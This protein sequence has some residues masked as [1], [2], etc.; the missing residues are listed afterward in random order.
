MTP[1]YWRRV[2]DIFTSAV[3]LPTGE[4]EA[5][6]TAACD[7]DAALLSEVRSLLDADATEE[8]IVDRPAAAFV[9]SEFAGN[10][11]DP[12]IG[13]RIG[14]YEIVS[15][16]GYGGMG[17]VYRALRVDA[18]YEKEV[19]IKLVPGGY[20]ASYVLQRMRAE[21]QIL[22][23][24]EHPNIARLIDGGATAEGSP[25]LVMELVD[26]EPL[27]RHAAGRRLS[28]RER[29]QL[30]LDVCAAVSYAHQRLVVHR[31]LKPGNILV[32]ANGTVKLLDFGIAKLLQPPSHVAAASAT[33][34]VMHALTPGYSSPEQLL[35]APITTASDV[36]SLGVVLY[37]LLT[38]CSPYRGSLDSAESAVHEVCEAEPV[39]PS[40]AVREAATAN[41][42]AI[43]RDLDAIILRALRKEPDRRYASVDLLAEDIR[44]HLKGLPVAARGE[45]LG[46]RMGKFLHRHRIEAAAAALLVLT[47]VAATVVSIR[48]ARVAEA[49]R[50]RAE[51]HFAS[52]RGLANAFLFRVHDAIENLPGSTRARELLVGTGLEYLHTLAAEAGDDTA[53]R[54]ELA[55]A[56]E[57]VADIQGRP[58]DSSTGKPRAAIQSYARAIALLEPIVAAEPDNSR[59]KLDLARILHRRSRLL[60]LQ[61][62]APEAIESSGRAVELLEQVA[63][64]QSDVAIDAELAAALTVHSENL[65]HGGAPRAEREAYARRS[66]VILEDLVREEPDSLELAFNLAGAYGMLGDVILPSDPDPDALEESLMLQR[67]ALAISE[68]LV[69]ESAAADTDYLRSL[70]ADRHNVARI[71]D[72][73]GNYAEALPLFMENRA[74]LAKRAADPDD[75][76]VLM[77]AVV[78]AWKEGRLNIALGRIQAAKDILEENLRA[79]DALG[80]Q[81]DNLQLVYCLAATESTLGDVHARLASERGLS[82]AAQLGHWRLA[83]E[84]YRRATPRFDRVTAVVTL[85]YM[86]LRPIHDT[87]T[88]LARSGAAIARLESLPE[89]PAR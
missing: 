76:Q 56:Y 81:Q 16:I 10:G 45:N 55:A 23:T 19:A 53:L 70:Y 85:D 40:A 12:W 29:L 25:Y 22:A 57:K 6:L 46:Y 33:V 27:D 84:F 83:R 79:F 72:D 34:T 28:V 42:G 67:K 87:R 43:S 59:Y 86:D 36:Y 89:S 49:E 69:A 50:A 52:V 82:R 61:G 4:R 7:G 74:L 64:S 77:D 71:L 78:S 9:G 21:R 75:A 88:G 11:G 8:A 60:L 66:V 39:R 15:L 68:R 38:G 18:E 31:D 13:R 51:R 48:Q 14:P 47:L 54:L 24:L 1:E 17:E 20:Q 5:F 35:G 62:A 44:R 26:G 41:A 2:K 32:T 65:F 3:A 73:M 30:F 80:M 37:V 63:Q 58:F